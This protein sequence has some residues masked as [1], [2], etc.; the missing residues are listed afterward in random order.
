MEAIENQPGLSHIKVHIIA[1]LIYQ[2]ML[3]I[4]IAVTV[5]LEMDFCHRAL[6]YDTFYISQPSIPPTPSQTFNLSNKYLVY[7]SSI[8]T[9]FCGKLWFVK[10]ILQ[11][12]SKVGTINL[13]W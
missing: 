10:A 5:D 13:S 11:G 6:L 4:A 12:S 9:G 2:C 8:N 1:I 3:S 7:N